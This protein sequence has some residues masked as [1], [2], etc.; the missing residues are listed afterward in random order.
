MS[1]LAQSA[2]ETLFKV[3]DQSVTILMQQLSVSY[4][5]ALIETG[6]NLLS[7]TVQVEANQPDAASVAK[8][9]ELY[10]TV[11]LS[12]L[13]AETIRRAIQLA[14]LKAIHNDRVDP[15]HQ[16]TPDS[17]GL[18]TAYLVSKL[19]GP[20]DDLAILDIAVGTGNLLTTVINQLQPTRTTTIHGYGVDND[21]TQ[22]AIAAMSM[23][24][25]KS[26]VD[27]FHQDAIDPLVMPKTTIAIGDL[28]VGYY[29][30]D[31]RVQSFETKA[32]N[33]HSYTHHLMM[34]RALDQLT[35]GGWGVFLV[36]TTIFQSQESA[37]LLKWMSSAAYLQGLLNLPANLFLD[38][39]SRKSVVVLQKHG[40]QA[41]QAGKVLLGEFPS[42]ENTR[43]FEAFTAQID[44]WVDQ[45][46][47]R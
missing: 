13:D 31:E 36:P 26:K 32:T 17:I 12:Q 24:L 39:K 9:T 40:S 42:F 46:I 37:G 3:F 2:T 6:D 28:P 15:N 7:Q 35:P 41:H 34:E 1:I 44:T 10:A 22:L 5:D 19:V 21:D 30:L 29:P 4:V 23:D 33:G 14:L 43:A 18:L 11:N 16:M 8:L 38:E 20:D 25:Q 47:S 45:N 27:L